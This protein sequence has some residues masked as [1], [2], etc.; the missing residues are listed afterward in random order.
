MVLKKK[1]LSG[2]V[3]L[4]I[5]VIIYFFLWGRLFPFSPIIIGFE[6]KEFNKA[7]IYYREGTD[8][9]GLIIIDSLI[10]QV[11]DFHQLNFK[12][13]VKIFIFNSDKDYTRHT[14]HKTRFV[15]F[16][17]YG[18]IFVSGK[19]RKESEEGKIHLDV[20]LK[21]ELSH[22]LLF[23]NMSLYHSCYYPCWL[24]EG[25]AVYS[26]NQIGVDGY[27]TKKETFDKIRNGYFLNPDDWGTLLKAKKESVKNFPLPNKYWF[28]YS[29]FACL[30]DNI[31]QNYGKDKFL[32][33]MTELLEEADDKKAFQ[34]I[35]GIEFN[36]Y[37]DDFK[38]RVGYNS[39]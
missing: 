13:R 9:S 19:A 2:T 36:K 20:Y 12:K 27:F 1:I 21:H 29:E 10:N 31:I 28:I 4:L 6:Q 39:K 16:P 38:N 24:L 33:Y 25:I 34:R 35:F 22:S 7:I 32:Q 8:I 17:I 37:I 26:A 14:G 23:Q 30:V 3:L 18:R 15:T 5:A 11:E